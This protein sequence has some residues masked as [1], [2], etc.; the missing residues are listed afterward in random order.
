MG[1]MARRRR[2]RRIMTVQQFRRTALEA[3]RSLPPSSPLTRGHLGADN[4]QDFDEDEEARDA[5]LLR[6]QQDREARQAEV[7]RLAK[8]DLKTVDSN[9]MRIQAL[10]QRPSESLQDMY[11]IVS[12]LD[13][14]T[15]AEFSR[16]FSDGQ[17]GQVNLPP[18]KAVE[19]NG[20]DPAPI[21]TDK[22]SDP[23]LSPTMSRSS[24]LACVMPKQD[25][26]VDGSDGRSVVNEDGA[27][28]TVAQFRRGLR[29]A[30]SQAGYQ[31]PPAR[32]VT[33]FVT[34]LDP[35][36]T[37]YVRWKS[38]SGIL[39]GKAKSGGDAIAQKY[40][41][42]L[43]DTGEVDLD[44]DENTT[45]PGHPD[46]EL[47]E[48]VYL[49]YTGGGMDESSPKEA[50]YTLDENQVAKK[51]ATIRMI[52]RTTL[53]PFVSI[54]DVGTSLAGGR[55]RVVSNVRMGDPVTCMC[56]CGNSEYCFVRCAR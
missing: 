29:M 23:S 35:E 2:A 21:H 27:K 32:L 4:E 26:D 13:Q 51:E 30:F 49:E 53:H 28:A 40:V 8:D 11:S 52:T 12:L 3:R 45:V 33:S 47:A 48:M 41:D 10:R 17:G 24:A 5:R 39:L 16:V 55:T 20:K 37:G 25:A 46:D 54:V 44:G 56:T 34:S 38:L 18:G 14:Q 31:P 42:L 9:R 43:L 22:N 1:I 50:P 15:L 7:A 36:R 19:V 6:E